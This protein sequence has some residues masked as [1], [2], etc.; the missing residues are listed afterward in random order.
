MLSLLVL[1]ASLSPILASETI[2]IHVTLRA[3]TVP[4]VGQEGAV[5]AIVTTDWNLPNVTLR[6]ELPTEGRVVDAPL[7]IA[8]GVDSSKPLEQ[9]S[10]IIFS[11][12]G[13]KLVRAVVKAEERPGV[14]WS[15]VFYLPLNIGTTSSQVG[16]DRAILPTETEQSSPGDGIVKG[17]PNE[18]FHTVTLPLMKPVAPAA[19]PNVQVPMS[20]VLSDITPPGT[21][22]VSGTWSFYDRNN[23]L[24]PQKVNLVEL[25]RGD[26]GAIL[27]TGWT[28]WSGNYT[29]PGV[30]NPGAAGVYCRCITLTNYGDGNF[31][32]V[33]SLGG[34]DWND[35]YGAT[36]SVHVFTD[37][38]HSMGSTAILNGSTNERAWWIKDDMQKAYWVPPDMTGRHVAEWSST[39][40]VG[41]YWNGN[42]HLTAGDADDTPDT[43]LHE[44]GHSV[45]Y[46]IYGNYYP[47]TTNCNPH[48]LMGSSSVGCGWTE[49]WAQTW[50]MWTTNDPIRS[51]PGGGSVNLE[52][53]T[54]GDGHDYGDTVEG[55]VAGAIW[56]ICDPT[57]DGYDTYDGSWDN[58]WDIMWNVNCDTFEDFW[59]AWKARGYSK[60]GPVKS[61]YQCT[62]D[63]NTWPTFYGLPNVST[64]EDTFKGNAMDLWDYSSDPESSNSELVYEITGNTNPECGVSIDSGDYVDINPVANWYGTSTVTISCSDG[65]RTQTDSFVVTVN[66]INDLPTM[67]GLPNRI[68]TE[69]G[70]WDNAIDLYAY[71]SDVET[72]DSSLIY[73][74]TGNT[75][76]SCGVTIDS[77]RYIDINPVAGWTGSSMVTVRATDALGSWAEDTFEIVVAN[78]CATCEDARKIPDG[79]W[80]R[81][82][83]KTVTAQ[84]PDCF[85]MQD[86]GSA[87][88]Q[89]SKAS[90][91]KVAYAPVPGEGTIVQ[92]AGQMSSYFAE[93]VINGH[94]LITY[95]DDPTPPA[96]LGMI[97]KA[98]GGAPPDS[99]TIGVPQGRTAGLYNI[100]LLVRTAGT[101]VDS[102]GNIW[103]DDGSKVTYTPE[104]PALYVKWA[105]VG[106]PPPPLGARVAI[107]GISGATTLSGNA[108]NVLRP[109]KASDATGCGGTL[110]YILDTDTDTSNAFYNMFWAHNWRQSTFFL[111]NIEY[112]DLSKY[113]VIVIGN[114]TGSW[115]D[116]DLVA[117]ILNFGKPIIAIGYGGS[118]FLDQ[119]ISPDL[120][121][122][123]GPSAVGTEQYGYV[124]NTGLGI[125]YFDNRITIPTGNNI[126]VTTA[127][128]STIKVF[129][130]PTSVVKL[131]RD[132]DLVSYWPIAQEDRFM[133]WGYSASPT[134]MTATGCDLFI[135]AL[136]YMQGK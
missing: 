109:R 113:D 4:I 106:T 123:W 6:I 29:F 110:A 11:T 53:A 116:A 74:I 20:P 83:L 81:V 32:S 89:G 43:V 88:D 23:S 14:V 94:I 132:N 93:R 135:N 44:M 25:R 68:V 112:A 46:F 15:D 51:Y 76:T 10:R 80:V 24:T 18:V 39:S 114:D 1:A 54:W 37:G 65:I 77:S 64:N 9:S 71:A 26:T 96:P 119:I 57:D 50:H 42:I 69:N 111:G 33:I 30:P 36:T 49:G 129:N 95:G 22:T 13:N 107:T 31:M 48:Y 34:D 128:A 72:P 40:T 126:A 130:P 38:A 62:I 100:G 127:A 75:N 125:F 3:D 102:T 121:I 78:L 115:A 7:T 12:P 16:F 17:Q 28:D 101:V 91:I 52:T 108:I 47:P 136:Y 98:M 8:Q 67:A 73:T 82:S 5:T 90:G 27:T 105:D 85:Y 97:N 134:T 2:P 56:D 61:I 84:F 41:T 79:G 103:I 86:D 59:T 104:K 60:H 118:H 45:M 131:L 124:A 133:Q 92:V 99:Y 55:R 122:G 58:I 120:N 21:L 19:G 66:S 70:S 35:A 63:Y 87:A 117:H